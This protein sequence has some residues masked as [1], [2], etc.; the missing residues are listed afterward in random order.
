MVCIILL[1]IPFEIF[2]NAIISSNAVNSGKNVI[3]ELQ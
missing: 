2:I 1:D 3:R